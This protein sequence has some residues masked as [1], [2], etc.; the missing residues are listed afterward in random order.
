LPPADRDAVLAYLLLFPGQ[1]RFVYDLV[2]HL[3]G[4]S[5]G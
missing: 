1:C 3:E 4:D 2:T 5:P